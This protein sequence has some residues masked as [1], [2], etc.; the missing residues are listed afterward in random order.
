MMRR[1]RGRVIGRRRT[2]VGPEAEDARPHRNNEDGDRRQVSLQAAGRADATQGAH[3]EAQ[4]EPADVDAQPFQDIRAPPQMCAAHPTG[5]VEMRVR[6]FQSAHSG[7]VA[8]HAHAHLE[9]VGGWR[10]PRRGPPPSSSSGAGRGQA[11]QC[12]CGGRG[13][14]GRRAPDCCGSPV[15]SQ[16]LHAGNRVESGRPFPRSWKMPS[17]CC[18][19]TCGTCW[20]ACATRSAPS[21]PE[22]RHSS[23]TCGPWP[24]PTRSYG[25]C[26]RSPLLTATALV[27]TVGH[28]GAF[29][30]ARQFASWLGLTPR[31]HSSGHRRRLGGI[32]KHGDRYLRCLLT[33][34]ARAVLISAQRQRSRAQPL[35][36]LH[37]WAV[38][39]RDERYCRGTSCVARDAWLRVATLS[40]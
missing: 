31:E 3:E 5:V 28:I 9:S 40:R 26:A 38:T 32:T 35:S 15:P 10:T 20:R 11:R 6:A 17:C 2:E 13:T 8:G 23:A 16:R 14:P 33:H 22:S 21:K 1:E 19:C 37:H 4:I 34:G 27:G 24:T 7:A 25:A 39:L 12:R 29:R 30:R 36:R 18:R